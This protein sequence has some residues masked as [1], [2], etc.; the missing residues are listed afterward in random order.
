MENEYFPAD[1]YEYLTRFGN[2]NK[3]S[4]TNYMSW[5]AFLAKEHFIPQN[6]TDDEISKIIKLENERRLDRKIYRSEK[7]LSNFRSTLR[8]YREFLNF[9]LPEKK[10]LEIEQKIDE[11]KKIQS[12]TATEKESVILSR[13]G[14]GDFRKRLIQ[15]WH[16]CAISKFSKYDILI[17][18]HIK[19]WK[20]ASNEERLDT[21]NGLLLLPNY[22]KVF[23]RGYISFDVNGKILFSKFLAADEKQMLGLQENIH[24]QRLDDRHKKYLKYHQ[25]NCFMR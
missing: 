14:Q 8:K 23:D 25:E 7:D 17:A 13:V 22:D 24:L 3:H 2:V 11:V 9:N 5:M 21:Y 18:S 20:D 12:I 1:F 4:R 19:P 6:L 15:Y 10:E 16:G